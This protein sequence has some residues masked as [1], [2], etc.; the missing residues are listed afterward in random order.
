[1]CGKVN[2]WREKRYFFTWE[3][4]HKNWGMH[5]PSTGRRG[6][7]QVVYCVNFIGYTVAVI[8]CS[9]QTKVHPI[10][11]SYSKSRESVDRYPME[12]P[13]LSGICGFPSR[14][15]FFSGI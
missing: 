11:P 10:F 3:L 1:M 4:V 12:N 8:S 15:A 7:P 14:E 6:A 2:K 5:V 9:L 13:A